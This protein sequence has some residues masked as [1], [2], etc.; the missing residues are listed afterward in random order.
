MKIL[1][2]T[3]ESGGGL[4]P[5]V[6]DQAHA[7]GELGA[8]VTVLCNPDFI[9]REGDRYELLV[10]LSSPGNRPESGKLSRMRRFAGWQL[11]NKRELYRQAATQKYDAVFLSSYAEYLAPIWAPWFKA[12]QK[13]GVVFGAM[14]QEPVRD[15]VVGP[16]WWHNWSVREAYSYLSCVFT[17]EEVNLD[18]SG[19][20]NP[21]IHRIVPMAPHRF[22]SP[23]KTRNAVREE[24][25]VPEG[26]PLLFSFGLIRDSKNT[27]Y[28]I[29]LLREIP[30][31][32]LL[33]AGKRNAGSQKPESHYVELAKSLG[34]QERCRWKFEFIPEQEAA[35]FFEASDLVM[36][37]Y[38]KDFRSASAAL[39]VAA[40]YRRQVIASAGQG[41]LQSVVK[42]YR[43]G[44][45]VEPGDPSA[46]VAAVECWLSERPQADWEAYER[47]NSWTRNASTVLEALRSVCSRETTSIV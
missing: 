1:Y 34:V 42:K 10:R 9:K 30:D 18:R 39:N 7:L 37:T 17:H 28:S 27:D 44:K 33:V 29:R 21:V 25:G 11:S 26:A 46:V 31:A 6:Q 32:Y 19:A 16:R 5:Y 12:L 23:A 36:L 3:Q 47:D 2:Y 24:L 43:L 13:R 35:D 45:W 4:L 14:V 38:S 41:S 8:N 15:F 40:R 22:P 20:K